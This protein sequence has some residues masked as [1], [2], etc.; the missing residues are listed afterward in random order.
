M[1]RLLCLF[2]VFAL[3]TTASAQFPPFSITTINQSH[4]NDSDIPAGVPVLYMFFS[5]TCP[6]CHQM[7]NYILAHLSELNNTQIV[8]M[9]EEPME[10]LRPFVVQLGLGGIPNIAIG[11]ED[12]PYMFVRR[13]H[14]S[15]LPFLVLFDAQGNQLLTYDSTTSAVD[16]I[17]AVVQVL[18]EQ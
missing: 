7:T 1:N 6:D 14:F 13:F 8:M 15:Q 16:F 12:P 2:F 17:P 10:N 5:P 9:T 4:F 3:A 18:R 11:K